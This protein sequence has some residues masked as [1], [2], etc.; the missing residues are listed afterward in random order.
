[1]KLKGLIKRKY[2]V[3][4]KG[5]KKREVPEGI[6]V[7][8][9]KC[10]K[11]IYRPELKKTLGICPHC[12]YY[13]PLSARGRLGMIVDKNSF[14]EMDSDLKSSNPLEFEGY[15]EKLEKYKEKTKQNEAVLTGKATIEG[16]EVIIAIM[17]SGFMM[18]SMGQVVGEKIARAIERATL[19]KIPLIIFTASGG[20]RMQEGIFSLMQM[21]KTSAALAKH[22]ANGLLY[23]S[24]LTDPT[25]GG[26]TASF[27]TLG[28][29]ILAEPGALVGFAGP[30]VIEQTIKQ[31]LPE[32]F[33]RAEF[34]MEKG[35]IDAIVKR[36]EMRQTL[37]AILR[38]H[39]K[40]EVR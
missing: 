13:Y 38:L 6:Y 9:P 32:G 36:E 4:T 8:C 22:D 35:Q 1:M 30:R 26:V 23:I 18:G 11:S 40:K 25:T 21:A 33:Q 12:Q 14:E 19:D 17:D 37:A 7:Q 31:K 16:Q 34:L 20:A 24:V 5:N 3:T 10:K 2:A 15:E 27:A 39:Q 28:D 29:I